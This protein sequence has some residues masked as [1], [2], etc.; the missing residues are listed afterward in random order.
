MFWLD[1]ECA[2]K[3]PGEVANTKSIDVPTICVIERMKFP[4]R[5]EW[6]HSKPDCEPDRIISKSVA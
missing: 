2:T 5:T 6:R 3:Y 1:Q 4:F